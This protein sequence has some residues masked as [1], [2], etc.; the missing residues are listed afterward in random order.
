MTKE[1]KEKIISD[2]N[3]L[4]LKQYL[5]PLVA[6]KIITVLDEKFKN[7]LYDNINDP[8]DFSN[9]ITQDL[10]SINNDLHLK[11]KYD[12]DNKIGRLKPNLKNLIAISR[13]EN[14]GFEKIEILKGNIGYLKMNK[15]EN[16]IFAGDTLTSA[17]NF[18][19]NTDALIIDIMN[20]PGGNIPMGELIASYFFNDRIHLS[21]FD[22]RE[23]DITHHTYTYPYVYGQQ[24]LNKDLYILISKKSA[25]LAEGFAYE[26]KYLKRAI[27][28]GEQSAGAAH[29]GSYKNIGDFKVYMPTGRPINPNTKTNWEGVGVI[30]HIKISKRDTIT[31]AH[32][33][34]LKKLYS[35]SKDDIYSQEL[36]SNIDIDNKINNWIK[37]EKTANT[38]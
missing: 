14:F 10:Q 6:E 1:D 5:F 17:M 4:L 22:F 33:L 7:G 24:Y 3:A 21:S 25:S 18:L 23:Y 8:L 34:A 28:I 35:G 31:T 11:L 19:G 9:I 27:I 16:P 29:S 20:N 13:K 32:L 37:D 15:F 36:K 2:I 38:T 12:P 26:L 30:P